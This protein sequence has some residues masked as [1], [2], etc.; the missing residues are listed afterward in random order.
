MIKIAYCFPAAIVGL[1]YL[2]LKRSTEKGDEL[3][4]II[5]L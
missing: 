4:E 5:L 1:N 3:E 2:L